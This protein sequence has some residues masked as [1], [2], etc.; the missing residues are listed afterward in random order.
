M[1]ERIRVGEWLWWSYGELV[2]LETE[3]CQNC[4][5]TPREQLTR[6]GE[7]FGSQ[8]SQRPSYS[9][10]RVLSLASRVM[11]VQVF[12]FFSGFCFGW[13]GYVL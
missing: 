12:A 1:F 10:W 13:F 6:R 11:T 8:R 5:Y 9:S 2:A 3:S 4:C 7:C